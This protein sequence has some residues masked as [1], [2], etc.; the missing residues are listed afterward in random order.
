MHRLMM[1]L[2]Q[3]EICSLIAFL[4]AVSGQS[5]KLPLLSHVNF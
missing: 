1:I 4:F 2:K 5:P 3:W